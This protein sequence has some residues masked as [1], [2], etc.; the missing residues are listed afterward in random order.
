MVYREK[1]PFFID[2]TL[3][4]NWSFLKNIAFPCL[5]FTHNNTVFIENFIVLSNYTHP[6]EKFYTKYPFVHDNEYIVTK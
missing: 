3:V 1:Y 5:L 4:P 2:V 6:T